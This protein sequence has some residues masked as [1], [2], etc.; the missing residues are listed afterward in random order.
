MFLRRIRRKVRLILWCAIA[1]F[2]AFIFIEWGMQVTENRMD[3][4]KRGIIGEVNKVEIPYS[5]YKWWAEEYKKRG[6]GEW[7]AKELAFE[8]VVEEVLIN[9]EL[10]EWGIS[11]TDEEVFEI[12]K[13]NPPPSILNDTFFYTDGKFDIKKYHFMLSNPANLRWLEEYEFAIRREYPRQLLINIIANTI[14]PTFKELKDAKV[15]EVTTVKLE[16]VEIDKRDIKID[17]EKD[18]RYLKDTNNIVCIKY[19]KFPLH[20]SLEDEKYIKEE[21]NLMVEEIKEGKEMRKIAQEY[22]YPI[23]KVDSFY[24]T[25]EVIKEEKNY[26]LKYDSLELLI[27]ISP[28]PSTVAQVE[29]K[30]FQF[31]EEVKEIGF[32]EACKI[33]E[34]K[35][36]K[37]CSKGKLEIREY[38][39][40]YISDYTSGKIIG[41]IERE[42]GFYVVRVEKVGK[43]VNLGELDEEEIREMV[44]KEK[45]KEIAEK[46]KKGKKFTKMCKQQ[47][48]KVRVEELNSQSTE[49]KKEI[50]DQVFKME[51]GEIKYFDLG[52]KFYIVHC[53]E[54]R[55]DSIT[56]DTLSAEFVSK[57]METEG[58]KIYV[59]WLNSLKKKSKIQDWR[60]QRD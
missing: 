53:V 25:L 41:P 12:I 45:S 5:W 14:R 26:L 32:E 27:P 30:V 56:I 13:N 60:Y 47:G 9:K 55:S 51:E 52:D 40:K 48:L 49:R 37:K 43:E 16:Y 54:R 7:E 21:V 57:W 20:P 6:I 24:T 34:K 36:E 11:L 29:E 28:S 15:K 10:N 46:I 35:I 39:L 42:D 44:W 31:L 8:R 4:R 18:L 50:F 33:Q 59:D 3:K 22:N 19:V 58:A 1:I 23:K 38:E 17:K 2:V